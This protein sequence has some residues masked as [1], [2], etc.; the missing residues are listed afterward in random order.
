VGTN[1]GRMLRVVVFSTHTSEHIH[2]LLGELK[3]LSV[4]RDE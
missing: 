4:T 3:T 2:R 1:A